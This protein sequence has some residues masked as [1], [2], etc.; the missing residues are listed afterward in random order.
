MTSR[1]VANN[2]AELDNNNDNNG[3]N[4]FDAKYFGYQP[5]QLLLRQLQSIESQLF[6]AFQH[7]SI[8]SKSR[9]ADNVEDGEH[10][11]VPRINLGKL[12]V[13]LIL[14]R[15]LVPEHGAILQRAKWSLVVD[16][17]RQSKGDMDNHV[18]EKYGEDIRKHEVNQERLK[19]L[20][21]NGQQVYEQKEKETKEL[22]KRIDK[23]QREQQE[24][25]EEDRG[26]EQSEEGEAHTTS[27]EESGPATEDS[28]TQRGHIEEDDDQGIHELSHQKRVSSSLQRTRD[29]MSQEMERMSSLAS[30]LDETG[31]Y[32][33]GTVEEHTAFGADT[34]ESQQVLRRLRRENMIDKAVIGFGMAIFFST[35]LY[36]WY[37]R[38]SWIY[39]WIVLLFDYV[40]YL[41]RLLL[42]Y[43]PLDGLNGEPHDPQGVLSSQEAS[44]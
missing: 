31:Q 18:I 22:Q 12:H 5:P 44:S 1:T 33:S 11:H 39:G 34:S 20:L 29:L 36:I 24:E 9:Y 28:S 43:T 2:D 25:E 30:V 15:R 40:I 41:L 26:T 17:Q 6:T 13:A 14:A 35:V 27:A 4:K 16:Q 23:A 19:T 37:K 8:E 21:A 42:M 7:C 38:F 32:L 10:P 3:P